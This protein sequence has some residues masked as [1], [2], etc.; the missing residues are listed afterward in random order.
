MAQEFSLSII[1]PVYNEEHHIQR[2]LEALAAQTVLPDEVILVDNNST[3]KTRDMTKQ[4]PFVRVL[5]EKTQGVVFARD[6]GF[7]AAKSDIIGRIDGDTILPPHWVQTVKKL[8][9]D[10][11]YAAVNGPVFYYDMPFSP[12]NYWIDHQVRKYLYRGAP[13][14]P[15]LFGSNSALRKSAWK[16]V[17]KEVCHV[18]AMHEDLDLAIHLTR[19]DLPIR[20]DKRLL[21]GTSSRRYDDHLPQWAHYMNMYRNSYRHHQIKSISPT[22]AVG[23][24]WFGYFVLWP[25]RRSY[26]QGADRR[27]LRQLRRGGQRARKNP[28]AE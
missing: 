3:D 28:M 13:H 27:S 19:A 5:H 9:Q 17:R 23:L 14:A 12:R 1:I 25:L 20:Y 16:K 2:C 21:A 7:D 22:I 24:Y 10:Q 6:T 26:D 15:F 11:H 8:M 18:R 4:F